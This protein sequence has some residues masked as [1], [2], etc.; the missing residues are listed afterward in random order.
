[1][2]DSIHRKQKKKKEFKKLIWTA[3]WILKILVLKS[4]E[5]ELINK[6]NFKNV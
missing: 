5:C 3:F 2:K 4:N 6:D 1:M